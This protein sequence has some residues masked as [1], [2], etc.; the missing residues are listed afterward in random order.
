VAGSGGVLV[1]T[2]DRGVHRQ[3]P[4]NILGDG[5]LEETSSLHRS[6]HLLVRAVG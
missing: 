5:L 4:L 1:G 2:H 6:Y 3:E